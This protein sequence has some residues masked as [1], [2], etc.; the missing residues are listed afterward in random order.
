MRYII[1]ATILLSLALLVG[2]PATAETKYAI[3]DLGILPGFLSSHATGIN[4]KTQIVGTCRGSRMGANRSVQVMVPFLWEKGKMTEIKMPEGADKVWT[5]PINDLG[6]F[7][8]KSTGIAYLY[9]KGAVRKIE[10]ETGYEEARLDDINNKGRIVGAYQFGRPDSQVFVMQDDKI[11]KIPLPLEFSCIDKM[12]INEKGRVA[13]TVG[14]P[15]GAKAS[16][17]WEDG[18]VTRLDDLTAHE[19]IVDISADAI[20]AR[21]LVEENKVFVIRAGVRTELKM[22]D[23]MMPVSIDCINDAGLSVGTCTTELRTDRA[24]VWDKAGDLQLL[25]TLGGHN[26]QVGAI[27]NAGVIV[28]SAQ[29]LGG[30]NHAVM[31]TPAK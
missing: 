30:K 23:G 1:C 6:S 28:G 11:T 7:P 29:D 16:F 8:M 24:I 3:K 13:A 19:S 25:P 2:D 22:L 10:V 12:V 21:D 4:G 26:S 5:G 31:W 27:N 15:D 17:L 14:C 20:L 9:A 18:K